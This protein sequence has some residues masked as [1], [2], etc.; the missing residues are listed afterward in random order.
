MIASYTTTST[1]FTVTNLPHGE[2]YFFAACAKNSDGMSIESSEVEIVVAPDSLPPNN[3]SISSFI[4]DQ[5]GFFASWTPSDH[6]AGIWGYDVLFMLGDN[7]LSAY[8][9]PNLFHGEVNSSYDFG[10]YSIA[11]RAVSSTLSEGYFV[12][13]HD[14]Y[15]I[16]D[17]RY[18]VTLGW[19]IWTEI[20]TEDQAT[21]FTV[22]S[23][24]STKELTYLET[25]DAIDTHYKDCTYSQL[26]YA[27]SISC[28]LTTYSL[29]GGLEQH[30]SVPYMVTKGPTSFVT[31]G[32][33]PPGYALQYEVGD[34][35]SWNY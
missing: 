32:Y 13:A 25:L 31:T 22:K 19:K 18:S 34:C 17:L 33:I 8:F 15:N 21:I 14:T 28:P 29:F 20:W 5:T 27:I 12:L 9:T 3:V 6:P 2:R 24:S 4:V 35:D 1:T 30:Y 23:C 11:V 16:G 26:G 10:A 7:I